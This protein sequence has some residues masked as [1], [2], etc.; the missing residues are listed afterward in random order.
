MTN[1]R[2]RFLS[3]RS[4]SE[5]TAKGMALVGLKAP[6]AAVVVV[7][8]LQRLLD[9]AVILARPGLLGGIS[10]SFVVVVVVVLGV[11]VVVRGVKM[12]GQQPNFDNARCITL[13][14]FGKTWF[15]A[16]RHPCL[17]W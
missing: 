2:E 3:P 1:L 8:G 6:I 16:F 10:L 13:V 17:F 9:M 7:V 14:L 5:V 4:L 12:E 15:L 11:I